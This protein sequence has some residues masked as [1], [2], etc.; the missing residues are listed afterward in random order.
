[1]RC[2]SGWCLAI[3]T[4]RCSSSVVLPALGGETMSPRWPRPMGAIRSITRRLVSAPG[5]SPARRNG[6]LRVDRGQVLE[7]RQRPVL[8]GRETARLLNLYQDAASATTVTG[9]ADDLRSVAQAEVPRDLRRNHD[10]VT[11]RKVVLGCLPQEPAGALIQ[12]HDAC[13]LCGRA[14]RRDRNL[15]RVPRSA[16]PLLM[17]LLGPVRPVVTMVSMAPR[18]PRAVP[19]G[20]PALRELSIN[21]SSSRTIA[22]SNGPRKPF[23]VFRPGAA[24]AG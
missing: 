9:Q 7:V 6:S 10:V 12:I 8:L 4:P 5:A 1:M 2:T 19:H 18:V 22:C 11:R 13:D 17:R 20:R 16:L 14:C 24:D 21:S 15:S 23:R 3:A